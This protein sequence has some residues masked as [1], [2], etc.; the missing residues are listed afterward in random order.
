M[1]ETIDIYVGFDPRE[2]VGYH[3]F[4]QSVL[5]KATVPVAF[6]PLHK[7]M[8]DG[9]D[10]QKDG[11]N[12]FIYSRFL[13]PYMQSY[14]GWAMFVD[15][16]DMVVTEDIANL[17]KLRDDNNTAAMVV[18]H[19]YKTKYPRKYVGTSLES[20]NESYPC[21]NWSSVILWNCGHYGNQ[22][23]TPEFV[24]KS[25]GSLLHRFQWLKDEQVK[26]LPAEWNALVGEQDV[27]AASLLHYT[28]GIPAMKHYQF[29]PGSENWHRSFRNATFCVGED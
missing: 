20:N 27:S 29:F 11:T 4:C 8:L 16:C 28:L 21:K 25:P 2:A 24:Q 3:T 6:H 9:F 18:K 22:I 5:D 19:D 10:G 15:G 12:A 7:P 23:L 14:R 1:K 17:W 13:V 26:S